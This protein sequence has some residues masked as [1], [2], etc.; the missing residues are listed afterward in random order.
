MDIK[1]FEQIRVFLVLLIGQAQIALRVQ[2]FYCQ[3]LPQ[4]LYSL[5]INNETVLIKQPIPDP[6]CAIKG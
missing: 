4:T 6:A 3:K 2:G 5:A 1:P